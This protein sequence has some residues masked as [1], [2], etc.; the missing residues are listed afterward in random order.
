MF[1]NNAQH[2]HS[3]T[4]RLPGG[5]AGGCSFSTPADANTGADPTLAQHH[6]LRLKGILSNPHKPRHHRFTQHPLRPHQPLLPPLAYPPPPCSPPPAPL[7]ASAETNNEVNR[8]M[9]AAGEA[10]QYTHINTI[11]PI[12]CPSLDSLRMINTLACESHM[13]PCLLPLLPFNPF[14]SPDGSLHYCVNTGGLAHMAAC[15]IVSIL[16]A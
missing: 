16:V 4:V 9:A 1:V 8:E 10:D 11:Q 3:S 15:I 2:Q 7:P 14:A 6:M 5:H 13:V 12:V